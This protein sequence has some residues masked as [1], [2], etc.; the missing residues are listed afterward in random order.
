[1]GAVDDE[2]EEEIKAVDCVSGDVIFD[3]NTEVGVGCKEVVMSEER[4][5]K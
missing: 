5:R 3:G 1:M 4:K 2:A